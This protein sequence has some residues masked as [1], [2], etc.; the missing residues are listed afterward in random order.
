MNRRI[1]P[2]YACSVLGLKCLVRAAW[3]TRSS[4]LIPPWEV[5]TCAWLA[6][7]RVTS[8]S[9][10]TL[11]GGGVWPVLMDHY[12]RDRGAQ[13]DFRAGRRGSLA[14]HPGP[15]YSDP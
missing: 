5:G 7:P 8:V 10:E 1:Q 11:P 15:A 14:A 12:T 2:T 3:R 6:P 4:S 13:Q 9:F